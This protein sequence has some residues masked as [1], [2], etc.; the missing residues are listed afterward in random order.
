MTHTHAPQ[1]AGASPRWILVVDDDQAILDLVE[2]ILRAQG[3][4]VRTALS[5]K[6]AMANVADAGAPPALLI[7]DVM[8]TGMDGLELT[9]RLL[10]QFPKLKAI[11]ISAQLEDVSWWP[12]DLA[13]LPFLAKPFHNDELVEAVREALAGQGRP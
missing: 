6:A 10:T 11:V 5:A 3:W 9:R 13:T 12:R 1:S 7:C 8:M 4:S 2:M